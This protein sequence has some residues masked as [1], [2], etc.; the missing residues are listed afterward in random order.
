[1]VRADNTV[2]MVSRPFC[3][4]WARAYKQNQGQGAVHIGQ[5]SY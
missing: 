2:F 4:P 3:A 1:M 5:F